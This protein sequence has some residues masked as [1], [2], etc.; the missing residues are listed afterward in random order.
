MI[1][2][3]VFLVASIV[4]V[5]SFEL[6][7]SAQ[8]VNE[9][10]DVTRKGT[11]AAE[12][13]SIPVGARATG[14]GGA[15]TAVT[16][17]ATAMY[18]NPAGLGLI[19]RTSVAAEHATWLADI[20]FNYA[21]AAFPSRYGT[22][23]VAITSMSTPNMQ[24]TTAI[25]QE[26]TGETFTAT[27]FA[28]TFS[29]GK[30]LTDRFSF[31]ASG[32]MITEQ[33]WHSRARGLALDLGTVFE[34]PFKG[35][36]LGASISNFGTKMQMSGDD[37]LVVA[38]IDPVNRG[39]NESNRAY[40]KVDSFNLPLIMRIGLAGEMYETD[41]IRL[42]LSMDVLSP[43]NSNQYANV[44]LEVGFLGDLITFRGGYS[45]LF[46]QDSIRSLALG[47]G[48]RYDFGFI[49]VVMDYAFEQHRYFNN[50]S[51]FSMALLF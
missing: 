26:G 38:D 43:N 31:G 10:R 4:L 47:A 3:R 29:W 24:V 8:F 28:L 45:E 44:G 39:N 7:V 35:I 36:R 15:V 16:S 11:T 25:D 32:K 2:P 21:A 27:S 9:T 51:R 33:I 6:R 46:L 49:G 37:L 41:Q 5:C 34:T 48:L 18:W 12:F 14:M 22:V 1:N 20:N 40:L 19:G 23:G 50:V 42:T 17:D 30:K 13:L